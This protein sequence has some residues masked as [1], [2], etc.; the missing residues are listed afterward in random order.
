MTL[1]DLKRFQ[2]DEQLVGADSTAAKKLMR[3]DTD[4]DLSDSVIGTITEDIDM[5]EYA[6]D[7]DVQAVWV[8]SDGE[9]IN[10]N[11]ESGGDGFDVI[12]DADG[13]DYYQAIRF[14]TTKIIECNGASIYLNGQNGA[15]SGN[16]TFRIETDNYGEPSGTLVHANATAEIAN[17]SIAT[18]VWNK[19]TLTNFQ[20]AVGTYWLVIYIPDQANDNWWYWYRDGNGA[21][22]SVYSI[23]HGATWTLETNVNMNYFRIYALAMQN[24]AE[25]TIKTEGQDSMKV[26]AYIT[27]SLGESLTNTLATN[28]DMTGMTSLT[29]DIYSSRTGA[30]IKI[31]IHDSGG[32]LNELTPTVST[33]DTWET[34]TWDIS[35]IIDSQKDDIDSIIFTIVNADADNT[36][37]LDNIQVSGAPTLDRTKVRVFDNARLT[38]WQA[39]FTSETEFTLKS[40][41]RNTVVNG[42]TTLHH[43]FSLVQAGNPLYLNSPYGCDIKDNYLFIVSSTDDALTI[44][45]I[46]DPANVKHIGSIIGAGAPNYLDSAYNVKIVGNYAYVAGT[47]DDAFTIF[48]ISNLSAPSHMGSISGAGSPNYLQKAYAIDIVGSKAYIT[49]LFDYSLVVIDISDP[50]TPVLLG[51]IHGTGAPPDKLYLPYDVK[52]IDDYAYV[53]CATGNALE[54][55]DIS[56]PTNISQTGTLTGAGAPNYLGAPFCLIVDGNYAYIGSTNDNALTII[57]IS[58]PANPAFTGYITGSGSPNYLADPIGID[59]S[60]DYVMIAGG[61]EN[62]LIVI[63]VSDPTTPVLAGTIIGSGSPNWLGYPTNLKI[64]GDYIYVPVGSDDAIS[65][66][67]WASS[68]TGIGHENIRIPFDAWQGTFASGNIVKFATA[69]SWEDENVIQCLYDIFETFAEVDSS[70][71]DRSSYFGDRNVGTLHESVAASGTALKVDV[72]VP[73]LI[74]TGETLTITEGS[75]TEDVTVATGVTATSKYPPYIELTVSALANEYTSVATVVWKE[76]T[77]LDTDFSWD[78]EYHYCDIMGYNISLSLD[79]GMTILRAIEEVCRHADCFTFPDNWGAEKIHTFRPHY[80]A[81]LPAISKSTNLVGKPVMDT[82]ELYNEFIIQ[83]GY[84]YV[85]SQ[86]MYEYTYPESDAENRSYLRN[87]FKRQRIIKLPGIWSEAYAKSIAAH[88]YFFWENGLQLVRFGTLLHGLLLTVGDR[89]DFDS[90]FPDLTTELE[91]VGLSGISLLNDATLNFVAYVSEFIFGNYF[92]IADSGIETGDVLW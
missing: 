9:S 82:M 79:R 4:G 90:D 6:T 64:N 68:D 46:S 33:A 39:D 3:I 91:I 67:R 80:A 12:G 56:D 17:G 50:T 81:S 8:S 77:T 35:E 2:L 36:F 26:I 76:R 54:I 53:V 27:N 18:S 21:G 63:N 58:D 84:D 30:N 10:Q 7:A 42:N 52:I 62:A 37:Y 22:I 87:G 65:V 13:T 89:V 71:L 78:A 85:N 51:E 29:F 40:S 20:L 75:T 15:P 14:T 11:F 16:M 34:V 25:T 23:D 47:D 92:L 88:K 41:D 66:F 49:G 19:V 73:M 32:A 59:K 28:I 43:V 48:D 70:L 86:A 61:T 1:V 45:D 74:K 83:Y 69:I 24:Y 31:G 44:F 38:Q 55:Y 60:G 57:D 5:M 72:T